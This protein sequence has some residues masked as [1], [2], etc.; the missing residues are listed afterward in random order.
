MKEL[1]TATYLF[2]FMVVLLGLVYPLSMT[3]V[4]QV[5]LSKQASGSLIVVNG[6]V[7]GSELI[8]QDFQEAKYFHARPS[9][10]NY[11]SNESGGSN[12]APSSL[13][14]INRVNQSVQQI[15]KEYGLN[16]NQPIPADM[17]LTSAS[18]LEPYI[19][20]ANAQLQAPR[21]AQV[22]DMDEKIILNLIKENQETPFFSETPMI[23]VVKLN[24]ELD[25]L[26]K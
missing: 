10:V 18:G 2:F 13:E 11:N 17:V 1:K 12:L 26:K 9:A 19:S 7:I 16:P 21:I 22:R 3:L 6:N 15:R 20:V 8:G 25:R 5:F 24:I 14:L 4:S 23:N